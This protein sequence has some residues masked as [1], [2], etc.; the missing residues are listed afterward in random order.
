M[1]SSDPEL[2]EYKR[3]V[4]YRPRVLH[5]YFSCVPV[6]SLILH[7]RG[8]IERLGGKVRSE[9]DEFKDSEGG[10]LG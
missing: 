8:R 5:A 6:F 7:A 1:A 9:F 2:G 10:V 4:G 3:S